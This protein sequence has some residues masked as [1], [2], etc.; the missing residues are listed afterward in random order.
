MAATEGT[1][2]F[3]G[4]SGRSYVKDMYLSDTVDTPVNFDSGGGASATSKD[5]VS[6]PEDVYL[7]DLAVVTGAAQTKLHVLLDNTSTGNFLRHTLHLNTL[8]FRP[9][10]RLPVRAR[11][12]L[13][14][15]QIA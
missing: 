1:A 9:Q 8:A 14:M 11:Q 3:I 15:I 10:M 7:A 6:F 4:R 2:T 13:S 12:I 5:E